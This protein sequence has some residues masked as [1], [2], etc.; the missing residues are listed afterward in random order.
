MKITNVIFNN[1]SND[2]ENKE[3]GV[4]VYITVHEDDE[5]FDEKYCA[6]T[7]LWDSDM[8]DTS[9]TPEKEWVFWRGEGYTSQDYIDKHFG[10]S[11]GTEGVR[12]GDDL[13]YAE[14]CI[15]EEFLQYVDD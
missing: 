14:D 2:A 12:Y 1:G 3:Y 4:D 13:Q 10:C 7:L 11:M 5:D 8:N 6:G 9:D 15:E